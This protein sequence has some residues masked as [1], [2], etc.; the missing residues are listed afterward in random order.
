MPLKR[1]FDFKP[2]D[3]SRETFIGLD[4][5]PIFDST[6]PGQLGDTEHRTVLNQMIIDRYWNREIG[7]ETIQLFT[8][9]L[10]RRMR[11]IMPYYNKLFESTRREFDA[12]KTVDITT[13]ASGESEQDTIA[14]NNSTVQASGESS[15]ETKTNSATR[16]VNSEFPQ[17]MLSGSGDYATNANDT[18]GQSEAEASGT[19]TSQNTTVD[20]TTGNV[21]ADQSSTSHMSGYQGSPAEL[22]MAERATFMNVNV[23][24]IEDVADCFMSVFN[25]GDEQMPPGY[26]FNY[27]GGY[28]L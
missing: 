16:S 14:N 7:M 9:A 5:Y 19:E 25:N 18:N 26:G 4:T 22:I 23:Q 21:K 1:V 2:D 17:T 8:L 15:S 27:Y 10:G 24:I 3:V 11:E 6:L 28:I 20:A 13:E 12:L